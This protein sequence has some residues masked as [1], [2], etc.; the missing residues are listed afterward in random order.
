[1]RYL[2]LFLFSLLFIISCK[3]DPKPDSETETTIATKQQDTINVPELDLK[4]SKLK[5]GLESLRLRERPGRDGKEMAYLKK[6]TIISETG[7]VS[8]FTTRIK[9]RGVW[10]DEPWIQIK[11]EQG[12]EGWVYGGGVT[13]EMENPSDIANKLLAIRLKSF[14]GNGITKE[15]NSYR[16]A[17]YSARNSEDF[18]NV[19]KKGE[20]L[21]DTMVTILERKIDVLSLREMPDLFWIEEA[22]PGYE[23]SLVAEGTIYYLFQNFKKFQQIAKKTSGK[24]DDEFVDLNMRVHA[25][26]SIEYFFPVWFIQ[27]WDYGGH[28]LLGQGKHLDILKRVEKMVKKSDLFFDYGIKIKDDIISDISAGGITYWEPEGKIRSELDEI[29]T[30]GLSIFTDEDKIALETRRKMFENPEANNIEVN[31]KSGV[32]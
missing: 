24:E 30:A 20:Q 13:F 29:R 9:L 6:G 10:F 27:T 31:H 26:D 2:S 18:S 4:P 19:F 15:L 5:V 28:S 16:K 14:F 8:D 17:Y 21:R 11:T 32:H 3:S 23:T 22:L 25:G 1:M 7:E 12:L